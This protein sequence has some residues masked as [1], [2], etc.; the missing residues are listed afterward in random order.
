MNTEYYEIC[1]NMLG[2]YTKA[3]QYEYQL[4]YLICYLDNID[5]IDK[6][7]QLKRIVK[8]LY[9]KIKIGEDLLQDTLHVEYRKGRSSL[10]AEDF[11]VRGMLY[12]NE[13]CYNELSGNIDSRVGLKNQK[14]I[15]KRLYIICCLYNLVVGRNENVLEKEKADCCRR[16]YIR[17]EVFKKDRTRKSVKRLENKIRESVYPSIRDRV[18]CIRKKNESI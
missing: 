3:N 10:Y 14:N 2:K 12:Y 4:L 15:L 11:L 6:I 13:I 7:H 5:S 8:R 9:G 16:I 18:I 17:K 1:K